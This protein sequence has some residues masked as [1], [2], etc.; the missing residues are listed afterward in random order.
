MTALARKPM[1]LT[2]FLAWEETQE[3]R[4]E[5]DGV[6]PVA[7]TGGTVAHEIIG[8]GLRG[9]LGEKL[10][11]G[12]C[13]VMGPTIKI[14]VMGRIRYPDALVTCAPPPR[15]ATIVPEPIVV[16]EILSPGTSRTDRIEKLRE[17]QATESI[18]RYV[19]LEQDSIAAT[20]FERRDHDWIAT[21][22]TGADR[23]TMPEIGIALEL[24]EIYAEIDQDSGEDEAQSIS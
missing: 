8:N 24:G 1:T 7:M 4:W 5:F 19:I 6:Q 13:R 15:G 9:R 12:P 22:L 16:F 18:R 17:Y 21:A 11:G 23:L 3:L 10:R 20:V 2:A 14:E